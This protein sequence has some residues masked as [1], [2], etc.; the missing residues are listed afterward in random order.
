MHGIFSVTVQG[1]EEEGDGFGEIHIAGSSIQ[2]LHKNTAWKNS[3]AGL[4]P[5]HYN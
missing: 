1:K 4:K 3:I 2:F 5:L